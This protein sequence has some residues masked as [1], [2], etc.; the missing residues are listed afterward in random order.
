M[1]QLGNKQVGGA[2]G[3]AAAAAALERCHTLGKPGQLRSESSALPEPPFPLEKLPWEEAELGLGR[4]VE[5]SLLGDGREGLL[6]RS[7][8]R[9]ECGKE[10]VPQLGQ[11]G[12]PSTTVGSLSRNINS[13]QALDV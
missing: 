4:C 6:G 10:E 2:Q 13:R 11:E 9:Q 12:W 3:A 1:V 7:Q 5:E 8:A